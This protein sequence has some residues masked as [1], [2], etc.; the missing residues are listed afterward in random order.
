VRVDPLFDVDWRGRKSDDADREAPMK[1]SLAVTL[2]LVFAAT[3]SYAQSR[4][5]QS[6]GGRGGGGNGGGGY[7]GGSRGGG[8]HGGGGG[9]A[10]A[11]GHGPGRGYSG[12][13]AR[14]PSP[15][16]GYY[17]NGHGSHGR[18]YYGHGSH[19]GRGYY[20]R[21]YYGY[22]YGHRHSYYRGYYGYPY[23]GYPYYGY[24]YGYGYYPWAYG[25]GLGL[26]LSVGSGYVDAGYSASSVA[27]YPSSRQDEPAERYVERGERRNGDDAEM[28]EL[29]FV[30]GP[31]DA[32]VYVDD[33]FRGI[34]SRLVSVR[35]MPGT[36]RVEVVRPGYAVAQREVHVGRAATAS[37]QIDL[38]RR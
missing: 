34:A 4:G 23:Y 17:S 11:R 21:G 6:G 15:G 3:S 35:V 7:R 10:V 9:H 33:E 5:G 36:H 14:H 19:Y 22:G 8:G 12:A 25:L 30:V 32:S 37:V 2:L 26:S 38:E 29:Q 13:V 1:K 27:E 18:G 16:R 31:G 28:A 20:G 24:G